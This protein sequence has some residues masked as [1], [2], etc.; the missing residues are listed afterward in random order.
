MI[1]ELL[2]FA[3]TAPEVIDD[4][5]SS[6]SPDTAAGVRRMLRVCWRKVDDAKMMAS[7]ASRSRSR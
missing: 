2:V 3:A 6:S 7:S 1:E 5:S 4:S